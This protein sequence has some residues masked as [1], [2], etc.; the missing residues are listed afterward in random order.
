MAQ[1]ERA[2]L[3]SVL[4]GVAYELTESTTNP[5]SDM[6]AQLV[7]AGQH[8]GEVYSGLNADDPPPVDYDWKSPSLF[9]PA[10]QRQM[11]DVLARAAGEMSSSLTNL[12]QSPAR[13]T[14]TG[15]SQ[16]FMGKIEMASKGWKAYCTP[17][18]DGEDNRI[19][20]VMLQPELAYNWVGKLLGGMSISRDDRDLSDLEATLVQ[21]AVGEVVKSFSRSLEHFEANPITFSGDSVVLND[22]R[23]PGERI[24]E[25]IRVD[26]RFRLPKVLEDEEGNAVEVVADEDEEGALEPEGENISG[27]TVSLT[28]KVD[29]LAPTVGLSLAKDHVQPSEKQ[30]SHVQRLLMDVP[31]R[32]QAVLGE[33]QLPLR[34]ILAVEVGDVLV[35]DQKAALPINARVSDTNVLMG[36]PVTSGGRYA[37]QTVTVAGD[38]G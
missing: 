14:V 3:E 38:I 25:F 7:K 9:M 17:L 20:F 30:Q 32:V 28:M 29:V 31:I 26:F 37:L 33:A 6:L 13:M 10:Q 1:R 23:L 34:K 22:Y 36:Y 8:T 21:D 11:V 18:L 15:W 12:F 35:I 27:Q 2:D 5:A 19:G 4:R 16:H 24:D